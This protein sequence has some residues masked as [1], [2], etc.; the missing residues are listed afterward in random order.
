LDIE[1]ASALLLVKSDW[2][3]TNSPPTP[4]ISPNTSNQNFEMVIFFNEVKRS[5]NNLFIFFSMK[6]LKTFYNKI[7]QKMDFQKLGWTEG[8]A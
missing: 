5:G 3:T 8:A 6:I 2:R 7:Y 4:T 1:T